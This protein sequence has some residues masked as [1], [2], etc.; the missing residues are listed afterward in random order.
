MN[1]EANPE[2]GGGGA[3][4]TFLLDQF[5][6][7]NHQ[8]TMYYLLKVN[9]LSKGPFAFDN[10]LLCLQKWVPWLSIECF[11]IEFSR[12]YR[13]YRICRILILVVL[14]IMEYYFHYFEK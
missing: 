10:N 5:G 3:W 6:K 14:E 7:T 11:Q 13:I 8:V 9:S 2:A 1:P 12:T 4:V